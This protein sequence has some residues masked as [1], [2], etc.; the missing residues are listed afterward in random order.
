MILLAFFGIL[1]LWAK[2]RIALKDSSTTATDLKLVGYVF[3]LMAAG[4]PAR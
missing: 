2:E 4:G 3:M 1:W